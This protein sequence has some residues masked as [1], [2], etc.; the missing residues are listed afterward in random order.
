MLVPGK[1]VNF[2]GVKSVVPFFHTQMG[3]KAQKIGTYNQPA[4]ISQ[5]WGRIGTHPRLQDRGKR[6]GVKIPPAKDPRLGRLPP[7]GAELSG[8]PSSFFVPLSTLPQFL[9]QL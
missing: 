5:N 6:R 4:N 8:A 1:T 2:F 3:K 9:S 7:T